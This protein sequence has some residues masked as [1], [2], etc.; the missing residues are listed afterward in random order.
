MPAIR[1]RLHELFGLNCVEVS[2]RTASLI[3]EGAAW[4][5]ADRQRL[6]L[7]KSIE[8][9]LARNAYMPV[10]PAGTPMPEHGSAYTGQIH[11]Y[12]ADPRDGFGKFQLF[13]PR[14]LGR[15]VQ[16]TEA[17]DALA[18]AAVRVD[19]RAKPLRERLELDLKID[20]DLI[21][22]ATARSILAEDVCTT[23]IHSLEF[24]I[25]MPTA[26]SGE[27]E[28]ATPGA[29]PTL[30]GDPPG[31]LVVRS[32]LTLDQS[33]KAAIPGEL[34]YEHEP[35]Y[36]DRGLRPP[37]IQDDERLYYKPCAV[38][39]RVSNDPLCRCASGY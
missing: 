17:R 16:I 29:G 35:W 34:L 13:T 37:E 6:A 28:P 32:N 4:M 23:E 19:A 25:P 1:Q 14:R 22:T 38:C 39:G 12:C 36:F 27:T 7:A 26:S 18:S 10:I 15:D 3:A 31:S 30:E 20:H 8:L 33:D 24:A 9:S 5:A 21:L 2:D 11:L